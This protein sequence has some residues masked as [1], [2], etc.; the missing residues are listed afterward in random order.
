[1]LHRLVNLFI[2][3]LVSSAELLAQNSLFT[4]P[5]NNY[6]N[7]GNPLY[8]KNRKPHAAYWQQDVH[9]Q[10]RAK[11][12]TSQVDGK[13][14]ADVE[15]SEI[16]T[17]WNNSPDTLYEVFFHLYQNAFQPE[18]YL[19][20]LEQANKVKSSFGPYESKKHG[21]TVNSV[22]QG[23][24][25]C[26]TQLDNTIL[27]I[28][29]NEPILPGSSAEFSISFRTYFDNGSMRR[30]M[31]IFEPAKGYLHIDGVHWYPRIC[32]YDAKFRWETQQH[33]GKEFYGDYGTWDVELSF[34]NHYVVEATGNLLNSNEVYP[35]DLR[36]RLDIANFRNK[37]IGEAPSVVTAP[38]GTFKT[39]R[40]HAENVHDFAFTADPTYRIGETEWNGIKCVVVVQE[41]NAA[42]WQQT[43]KFL[44]EVVKVYSTD[45]GMFAYPK[46]V[47][48]DA[49]DGMEYPMITLNGGN[50]PGHQYVIAHEVGHNWFFGMLGN[51]E[52]YRAML[53]EGFTQFLTAWSLKAISGRKE[54]PNSID[55]G[56]VYMG[57][58]SD[59]M[60]HNDAFLNTHSDDFSS[61]L[62]HGG[63]YRHVYYKTA[64]MLYNLQYVLGDELFLQA[65]KHYVNK[66]KICHPY[67]EDFR[68]AI[69]EYA[70]TDLTWFFDQW[71]ETTKV[72]DY[73]IEGKRKRKTSEPVS[74][75][76]ITLKR[77]EEMQMPLD[78]QVTGNKGTQIN[79]LIPNTW[80][81]KNTKATVLPKWTGW[82]MLNKTY[83]FN[84]DLPKGEKI[85]NIVIDPTQRLADIYRLDNFY[86]P[87]DKLSFDK[88][89]APVN[90]LKK[91][92]PKWRSVSVMVMAP[93]NTGITAISR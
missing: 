49:R 1:M 5:A 37:P 66:W 14:L 60:N 56:T 64:T 88:G 11:V 42:G 78:I 13:E 84:A 68:N 75:Y 47:A 67:P 9:Y 35:G 85:R 63:G 87:N 70:K 19:H 33:L 51:N 39:W 12:Q 62:G 41:P 93:A 91:L 89:M 20:K 76:E 54:Y 29:L 71:M 38:D 77:K 81:V 57:Y 7:T 90:D 24:S 31:K 21:T 74:R 43:P 30:R 36:Q 72:I 46:I 53:D 4:V 86:R 15:G 32:V 10:I 83:T 22:A 73:G 55:E 27:K 48:A 25:A 8:W 61:A 69:T 34:P 16:L 2:C 82:G 59:A 6:Q 92:V 45:F 23:G 26:Q 17:Y 79:Y 52:T 65:M 28:K 3:L 44:A 40:Y 18:S 58:L 80:F 50:W